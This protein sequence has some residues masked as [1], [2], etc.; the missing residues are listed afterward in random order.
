MRQAIDSPSLLPDKHGGLPYLGQLKARLAE[1]QPMVLSYGATKAWGA[2]NRM[3][4]IILIRTPRKESGLCWKE[5]FY[6][7]N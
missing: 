5:W 7:D 2:F 6:E 3:E 4:K 1:Q